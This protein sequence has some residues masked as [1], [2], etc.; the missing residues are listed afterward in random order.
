MKAHKEDR[1]LRGRQI[2]YLIYEYFRVTR[3]ND[4]VENYADLFT[5]SLRNDDIQEFD[6][7]WDEVLLSMTKIPPD[8]ILEGLYQLRIRESDK[9]KTVL[10][11]YDLEI[12]QKKL[13]P[14]CHRLKT[15]V[16]RSIEQEIRNKNFGVR[17][18]NFEKNAVVKNQGN[19]TA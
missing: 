19:K 3:A 16:K 7:K 9:L 14:D 17:N 2:A 4:S 12:H 8:D 6:S 18:G 1:F 10:E 11:L 5:I 15:M 13:G